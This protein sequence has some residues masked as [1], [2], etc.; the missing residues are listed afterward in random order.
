S[1]IP[2]PRALL[3]S[4][5]GEVP[6][7][8]L[9]VARLG[10]LLHDDFDRLALVLV[11]HVV[12]DARR[13]RA[14]AARAALLLRLPDRDD[15]QHDRREPDERAH[16]SYRSA[17]I[18]SSREALNAGYMPKNRPTEAEKPRPSANAHHGSEMGKPDARCTA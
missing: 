5:L 8:V 14:D 16:H 15:E 7:L 18:G 11:E 1:L 13:A 3:A 2:S 9:G 10:T 4:E 12:D 6:V 17:S